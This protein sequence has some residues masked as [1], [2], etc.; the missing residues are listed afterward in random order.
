[1]L[2][3][4][5]QIFQDAVAETSFGVPL[6]LLPSETRLMELFMILNNAF[7]Q[8]HYVEIMQRPLNMIYRGRFPVSPLTGWLGINFHFIGHQNNW[9]ATLFA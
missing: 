7:L 8:M 1:M 3:L 5:R 6:V 4:I 2:R 9:L